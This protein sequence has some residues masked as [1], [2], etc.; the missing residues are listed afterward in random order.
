MVAYIQFHFKNVYICAPE[1]A[2]SDFFKTNQNLNNSSVEEADV[3]VLGYDTNFN[4]DKMKSIC[5][6][7]Q[8]RQV[9]YLATHIDIFCPTGKGNIPDI[10][11][12]IK[13]IEMTTEKTPVANFGKP[14]PFF[15][16]TILK[17]YN[18]NEVLVIGDRLYTDKKLADN[19]DVDFA[20]VLTGETKRS[21]LDSIDRFPAVVLK[22][23]SLLNKLFT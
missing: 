19:C 16:S 18:K 23:M 11:S 6:E 14:H 1:I 20:L 12:F 17:K 9:I 8:N 15:L 7:L 3:I 4:Y 5:L 2:V 13:L 10:G 22:D 21:D